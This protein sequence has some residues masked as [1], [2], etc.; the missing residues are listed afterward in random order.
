MGPLLRE[1]RCQPVVLIRRSHSPVVVAHRDEPPGCL[2][3]H[4]G[5]TGHKAVLGMLQGL[6]GGADAGGAGALPRPLR[7][8][9]LN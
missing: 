9:L 8:L 2:T 3:G 6:L 1:T 4:T 7:V 5:H